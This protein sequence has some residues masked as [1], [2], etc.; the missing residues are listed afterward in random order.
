MA[1]VE[2]LPR[3]QLAEFEPQ[4]QMLERTMGF[5]PNSM[6]T[7]GRQPA[8]L[9]GFIQMA[10]G[11]YGAAD[12]SSVTPEL[13]RL[14]AHMTS[15]ASGCRYCQAHTAAEASRLG[16]SLEKVEAIWSFESSPLYTDAERAAL[17]L[18]RVAGTVPNA[19]T[20]Q[21]FEE[22]RRYYSNEEIVQI[23]AVIAL[24]GFLNR[25]ND[26]M[27]TEL[28]AEPRH[29]AQDHLAQAGWRVGKH[30]GGSVDRN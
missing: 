8:I 15:R 17:Q 11:I 22:L 16:A 9:R 14:I 29:F 7:M 3:E 2:P 27:A 20:D 12:G 21:H 1:R 6:L 4:F 30:G 10:L 24:F 5:V 13:S 19:A 28:E 23:M 26:T 18:A 25:W